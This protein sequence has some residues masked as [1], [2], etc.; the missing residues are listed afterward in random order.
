MIVSHR[1]TALEPRANGLPVAYLETH[2]LVHTAY[3]LHV[4]RND[5]VVSEDRLH[6]RAFDRKGRIGRPIVTVLLSGNARIAAFER[7]TWL[8]RGDVTAIESKGAIVM[9]QS[10]DGERYDAIAI[11]WDPGSLADARPQGFA[12]HR[13]SPG[14]LEVLAAAADAIAETNDVAAAAE[15]ATVILDVLRRSGVPFD[16]KSPPSLIEEVSEQTRILAAALDDLLSDL[17]RKPMAIDLHQVLGLSL[18]QVNRLV[19]DFNRR[20][21][22]NALGWRDTRGRRRL[23]MGATLMTAPN[24]TVEE[25]ARAVGYASPTA[26]AR[27]MAQAGLPPPGEVARAVASLR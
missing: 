13:L 15:H 25:V 17:R 27:A 2:A 22:F 6:L 1:R 7:E 5:G 26:F 9:R 20:Y 11:E 24:A 21:G 16:A 23:M 4:V 10:R 19:V 8:G 3:R 12:H 14:D 18:R